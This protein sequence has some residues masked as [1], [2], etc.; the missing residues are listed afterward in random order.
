ML[1]QPCLSRRYANDSSFQ[2]FKLQALKQGHDRV[3]ENST[4]NR[5]MN[6]DER[7]A[8][9]YGCSERLVS[10]P[11]LQTRYSLERIVRSKG[12]KSDYGTSALGYRRVRILPIRTRRAG[13]A[14]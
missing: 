6:S 8:R 7:D 3:V 2:A 11:F 13:F 12:E 9:K 4:G 14:A 5:A 10:R 1:A